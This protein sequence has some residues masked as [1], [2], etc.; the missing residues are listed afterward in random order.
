MQE[1]S[2]RKVNNCSGLTSIPVG[3]DLHSFDEISE[4]IIFSEAADSNL[5]EL[6]LQL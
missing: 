3:S 6:D 2:E 1:K 5:E 4:M